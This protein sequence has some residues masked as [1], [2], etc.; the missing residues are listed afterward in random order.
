MKLLIDKLDE[1]NNSNYW[2]NCFDYE[3]KDGRFLEKRLL[4]A[5][6]ILVK[7][8]LFKMIESMQT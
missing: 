7:A 3:S 1:E 8:F 5:V 2:L 4:S 6:D